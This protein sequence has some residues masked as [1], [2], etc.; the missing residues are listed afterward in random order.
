MAAV[1]PNIKPT[2]GWTEV[3]LE[4]INK[5]LEEVNIYVGM[6][7]VKAGKFWVDDL[8]FGE[9]GDLTDIVR[10]AG[11]PISLKRTD[12]DKVFVEGNRLRTNFVSAI[13]TLPRHRLFR[14]HGA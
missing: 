7:Q 10:R 14:S 1:H 13:W 2:Q 11:T 9:Y 8:R 6:W 4:Y 5:D 12:R 3:K